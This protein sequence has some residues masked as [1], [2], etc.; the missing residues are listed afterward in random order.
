MK[1][2]DIIVNILIKKFNYYCKN[3][4]FKFFQLKKYSLKLKRIFE[5]IIIKIN[6]KKLKY[7]YKQILSIKKYY[8]I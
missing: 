3:I 7:F 6:I 8:F 4:L 2:N 1:A 5:V